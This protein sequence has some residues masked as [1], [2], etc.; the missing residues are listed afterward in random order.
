MQPTEIETGAH[1]RATLSAEGITFEAPDSGVGV[2]HLQTCLTVDGARLIVGF[3]TAEA[4]GDGA[5]AGGPLGES[6]RLETRL[7]VLA[8]GRAAT[9]THTVVNHADR[10]LHV[11]EIVTAL[12]R[13]SAGISGGGSKWDQRYT[14]SDNLRTEK[15]PYCQMEQ[16]YVRPLPVE[17]VRLGAG[18]DQPLP[19]LYLTDRAYRRG[20]LIAAGGQARTIQSYRLAREPHRGHTALRCFEIAHELPMSEGFT[21]APGERLELDPIYLELL[22]HTHPQDAHRS[23]L[24]WLGKRFA[25]RGPRSRLRR[26]PVYC[27]WN[28]GRGARQYGE[29]LRTTARFAAAHVPAISDFLIDA[30]WTRPPDGR[31]AGFDTLDRFYH[32]VEEAVDR[33][34]FPEGMGAFAEEL[35]SLGLRPGLWW[36]PTARL[37]S[38]L[39]AE[40]P[41]WFLGA[42]DGGPFRIGAASGFL[43]L[44]HPDAYAYLD[45]VLSVILGEW[46]MQS[47][48]MDF[49]SHMTEARHGRVGRVNRTSLDVRRMLFDLMRKHLPEDGAF[50]TCVAVGMGNP[51]LATHADGHRN[52]I[53]IG[54]GN[55]PAQIHACQWALPVLGVPGQETY[56]HNQD[57]VGFHPEAPLKEGRFRLTWGYIT[58]GMQELG[59][60]LEHL[61]EQQLA[62]LRKL[63][64]R[65]DQGHACRSPDENA[66]LGEALPACLYVDFPEGSATR[67]RGVAQSVALFNWGEEPKLVSVRR[68]ALGHEAAVEVEDF[69][70]G[71]RERLDEEF[72]VRRLEPRNAALLDVLR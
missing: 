72:L 54:A 59:G 69:W 43:D 27:T 31:R 29:E 65:C 40:H 37:D 11:R 45:G 20:L 41:D 28:Y 9:V 4:A 24:A 38:E 64:E 15:Y 34:K 32:G 42:E 7:A 58:Q 2:R 35:R 14:H 17:P 68:A 71:E 44:T 61:T 1:T 51:F 23:Y 36:T 13:E 70:S 39:Y 30:G 21:L 8:G 55:W 49:W 6:A 22:E 19:L 56:F 3:D 26:D 5:V 16:G 25:F 47:T 66:F 33:E 53:D 10:P 52:G 57:S 46:G 18:E 48:K 60:S 50:Y 62:M 63:T 12:A 67:E